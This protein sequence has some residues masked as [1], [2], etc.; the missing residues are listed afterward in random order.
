V[1]LL[2]YGGTEHNVRSRI[3]NWDVVSGVLSD[4]YGIPAGGWMVGFGILAEGSF[5]FLKTTQKGAGQRTYAYAILL[6]PGNQIWEKFGWNAASFAN[7]ILNNNRYKEELLNNPESFNEKKLGQMFESLSAAP[8]EPQKGKLRDLIAGSIYLEK[9]IA[10]NPNNLGVANLNLEEFAAQIEDLPPFLRTGKGWLFGGSLE[11]AKYLGASVVVDENAGDSNQGE[12]E[13]IEDEGNVLLG[14]LNEFSR[15]PEIKAILEKYQKTPIWR[16]ETEFGIEPSE[17]IKRAEEL[18]RLETVEILDL[19]LD[20]K[21]KET[22]IEGV[23]GKEIRQAF[24]RSI[25]RPNEYFSAKKTEFILQKVNE[26]EISTEDLPRD[27]FDPDVYSDWLTKQGKSFSAYGVSARFDIHHIRRNCLGRIKSEMTPAQIPRILQEVIDEL[28][29]AGGQEFCEEMA[30]EAYNKTSMNWKSVWVNFREVY[31]F[32]KYLA[33]LLTKIARES[34]KSEKVDWEAAYLYYADDLGGKWFDSVADKLRVSKFLA[35]LL[36]RYQKDNFSTTRWLIAAATTP[37]RDKL[38]NSEKHEIIKND[39]IAAAWASFRSLA[40]ILQGEKTP[41]TAPPDEVLYLRN[42]LREFL[43]R[44]PNLKPTPKIEQALKKFFGELPKEYLE[45][46]SPGAVMDEKKS[47]GKKVSAEKS[48]EVSPKGSMLNVTKLKSAAD[49]IA[50][51][52]NEMAQTVFEALTDKD[53]QRE[54]LDD[55]WD[56]TS[57]LKEIFPLLPVRLR[58]EILH[59]LS[60]KDSPRFIKEINKLYDLNQFDVFSLAIWES[61]VLTEKGEVLREKVKK[62]DA[63]LREF[64]YK[65]EELKKWKIPGARQE[66]EDLKKEENEEKKGFFQNWLGNRE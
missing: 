5:L 9:P 49:D 62:P 63:K 26:N 44:N 50:K 64:I 66:S 8:V 2:V 40:A 34:T 46:K 36:M 58:A 23:L 27:S 39:Q 56:K 41:R 25:L 4:L 17:F 1:R 16:W 12:I 57:S 61:F 42:E 48:K 15:V 38:T 65:S 30:L 31:F 24:L 45:F 18:F 55:F 19:Y 43:S 52:Q 7:S 20:A 10:V 37:V 60:K 53:L 29:K 28:E 33:N 6:D 13:K 32:K 35:W 59:L 3:G 47:A 14:D 54:L 22:K 11:N 51:R 21:D